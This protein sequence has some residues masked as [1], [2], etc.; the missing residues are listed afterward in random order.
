M[1]TQN[2]GPM[3]QNHITHNGIVNKPMRGNIA[4]VEPYKHIPQQNQ[5]PADLIEPNKND[6][7]QEFLPEFA[8]SKSDPKY[9]TLPYN[10][11]FTVNFVKKDVENNN[12]TQESEKTTAITNQ[13]HMTVHSIPL[14]VVNK[15]LA[16]P[17][18][19]QND[20]VN[21]QKLVINRVPNGDVKN[22]FLASQIRGQPVGQPAQKPISSV[23]PTSVNKQVPTSIYQTSSTKIQPVQ[24]QTL[25]N[26]QNMTLSP[27]QSTSTPLSTPEVLQKDEKPSPK[28]ALPPK[29]SIKPPPRQ[30]TPGSQDERDNICNIEDLPPKE[31]TV[32]I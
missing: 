1:R 13:Q 24:P 6:Q 21:K 12:W 7:N 15:S 11:K 10:T 5:L 26:N 31:I 20:S 23:A 3:P 18:M 22:K 30:T 16:T 29:P 17:L 32:I 2:G 8:A 25:T 4:A 27:P 14:N 28:P 19:A 9:Q